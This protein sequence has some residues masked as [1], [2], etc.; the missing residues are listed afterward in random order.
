MKQ[1]IFIG[2]LLIII[3]LS[4][5]FIYYIEADVVN[6]DDDRLI[7]NFLECEAAGYTVMESYPRQCRTADGQ[8][9]VEDIL[10][11]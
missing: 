10:N 9:F 3:A 8:N 5:W 7:T 2:F 1:M 4:A 6:V 11:N